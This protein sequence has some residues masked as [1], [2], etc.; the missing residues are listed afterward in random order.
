MIT[1]D[2]GMQNM[3]VRL[4]DIRTGDPDTRRRASVIVRLTLM[5]LLANVGF[6]GISLVESPP[7]GV[8]IPIA[9]SICFLA[10]Y[11]FA[12]RGRAAVAAWIM[13]GACLAGS[14]AAMASLTTDQ[15]VIVLF[16]L[17]AVVVVAGLSTTLAQFWLVVACTMAG[18]GLTLHLAHPDVWQSVDARQ[19]VLSGVALIAVV[20]GISYLGARISRQAIEDAQQARMQ[21]EQAQRALA[22]ANAD[23]EARIAERTTELRQTLVA[24]QTL[25][26]ELQSSLAAQ[27]ELSRMIVDLSLPIIPV[28]DGTVV[29]PIS[30]SIDSTRASRLVSSVL[31]TIE[32]RNVHIVIFDITGVPI[33]DTQVAQALLQTASAIRLMGAETILAGIRPEVA[34][35]LVGL[36][37]DL[38]LLRTVATLQEG[39]EL[40]PRPMQAGA[41][42]RMRQYVLQGSARSELPGSSV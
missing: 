14:F 17:A 16:F 12:R 19:V 22:Q 24:Q 42:R 25:A 41:I 20:S 34:Q 2:R 15:A 4:M 8:A 27:Q 9:S 1:G 10:A 31:Q 40:T 29:V 30:G 5:L 39:L 32:R 23:L 3:L 13:I 6:A 38:R 35:T 21:A 26:E 28:R 7:S 11:Q 36:G 37:I 33:V 18:A